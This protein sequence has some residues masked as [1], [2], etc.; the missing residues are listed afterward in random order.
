LYLFALFFNLVV[1]EKVSY[2]GYSVLRM[3]LNITNYNDIQNIAQKYNLD[4]W[5]QNSIEKWM[6]IMIPPNE[7]ILKEIKQHDHIVSI[8]DVE[9]LIQATEV[10]QTS[11]SKKRQTFF[12]YFPNYA[13]VNQWLNTQHAL[14]PDTTEIK[15]VGLTYMGTEIKAIRIFS[16]PT[17]KPAVL[18]QAC[19]HAREWI[20]VT[21]ALYVVQELLKMPE[22]TSSFDFHIIPV[23][24]VDGY[25]YTHTTDRLWRKNRQPN[26]GSTCV[27]TDL[28]RNYPFAWNGPGSSTNPCSDTFRGPSS[29][30]S[31]EIKA[32][33]AYASALS[34]I[35]FF[36]DIH[37]YGALF[38]SS[39]GYTYD[40]PPPADYAIM[41]SVMQVARTSIRNVRGNVY[42][43]G[44]GANVLYLVSGGSKDYFYGTRGV[45]PSFTLEILGNNFTP[46]PTQIMPMAEDIWAGVHGVTDYLTKQ[47]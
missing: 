36:L 12:D 1:L 34:R 44:S 13:Q 35:V 46:P 43:I 17:P 38:L 30:S 21:S 3:Q 28:N 11:I 15:T 47:Q 7:D 16:G 27:G 6:D 10:N 14:H 33:L 29:Q 20:T 24:N 31:P 40:Y 25:S 32:L 23:L 19:I 4:I 2:N 41:D 45:L 18:I 9:E 39:W 26:S 22:I 5:A 8:P 42:T 37:S